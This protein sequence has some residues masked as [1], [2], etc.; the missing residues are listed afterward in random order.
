MIRMLGEPYAV[1]SLKLSACWGDEVRVRKAMTDALADLQ[2]ANAIYLMDTKGIQIGETVLRDPDPSRPSDLDRDRS[3]R[4][5]MVEALNGKDFVLS[6]VYISQIA[7]RP[8]VTAVQAIRRDDELL[9]FVGANFD[10]REVPLTGELYQEPENWRQIKGDPAIRGGLFNQERIDSLMDARIDDA[11][12]IIEDLVTQ[13]GVFHGKLHFSASRATLWLIEDPFRYRILG[14]DDLI[15][16]DICLAYPRVDYPAG[17]VMRQSEVRQVLDTFKAL[18]FADETIYLR[19]GSLN[20]FNGI[21]GLNFS[22]DGS[23]YMPHREFLDKNL[24]FWVGRNG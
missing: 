3:T 23:H 7:R 22:C 20:I 2:Y 6:G 8:S 9:G 1:L 5:Y 4:P 24:D 21:V 19:S 12:V 16:P 15:D 14:F 18:R 17:A 11:L 10:L 13:R